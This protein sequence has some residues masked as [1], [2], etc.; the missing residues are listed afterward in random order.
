MLYYLRAVRPPRTR[1]GL[2]NG[3]LSRLPKSI[4][5]YSQRFDLQMVA[6]REILLA[7]THTIRR[8]IE[9]TKEI[10]IS[11]EKKNNVSRCYLCVNTLKD[12]CRAGQV[13]LFE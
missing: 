4:W 8:F 5:N 13:L 10:Y 2:S 11:K 9:P 12:S 7:E 1:I 6:G 3:L